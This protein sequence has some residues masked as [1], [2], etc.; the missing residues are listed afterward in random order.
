MAA[1]KVRDPDRNIPCA[2]VIGTL[3]A[4]GLRIQTDQ[5]EPGGVGVACRP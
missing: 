4:R 2:T 5:G 3:A 1:G